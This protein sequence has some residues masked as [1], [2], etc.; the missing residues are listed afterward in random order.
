ML[1]CLMKASSVNNVNWHVTNHMYGTHGQVAGRMDRTSGA[2]GKAQD[3]VPLKALSGRSVP[4]FH[5]KSN[6][7]LCVSTFPFSTLRNSLR[8]VWGWKLAPLIRLKC[9]AFFISGQ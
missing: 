7:D 9:V 5:F 8:P 4:T 2:G 6:L 1:I 3:S